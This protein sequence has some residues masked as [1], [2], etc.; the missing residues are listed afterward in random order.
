[1]GNTTP[2][3]SMPLVEAIIG[4]GVGPNQFGSLP[5]SQHT[6]WGEALG[7]WAKRRVLPRLWLQS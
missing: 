5:L 3:E 1:V 6:W 4:L 2:I 7:G